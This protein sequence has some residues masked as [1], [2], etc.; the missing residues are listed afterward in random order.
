VK[1][2]GIRLGNVISTMDG[3][4][5][6]VPEKPDIEGDPHRDVL[7]YKNRMFKVHPNI[8]TYLADL[9]EN[10]E[11]RIRTTLKN[12]MGFMYPDG[13]FGCH[14]CNHY[15][16]NIAKTLAEGGE[17]MTS[18]TR[19]GTPGVNVSGCMYEETNV[20]WA[21]LFTNGKTGAMLMIQKTPC[22]VYDSTIEHL[23]ESG[24][25]DQYEVHGEEFDFP[26]FDEV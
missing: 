12:G 13:V 25:L 26:T 11:A 3:A 19:S 21:S 7:L 18:H 2:K 4:D 23:V 22:V 6:P 24:Q 17:D 20:K 8:I 15:R 9:P 10:L 5:I 14:Y 16:T 1:G